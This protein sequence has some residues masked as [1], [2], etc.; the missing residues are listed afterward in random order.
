MIM[1]SQPGSGVAI[2]VAPKGWT[3]NRGRKMR[4]RELPIKTKLLAFPA[5]TVLGLFLMSCLAL[6]GTHEVLMDGHRKQLQSVLDV[7]RQI[8][9]HHHEQAKSGRITETEAKEQAKAALK[10]IRF[11]GNEYCF[12]YD[13]DG[14]NVMHPTRADFQGTDRRSVR[15]RDG[16]AYIQELLTAA[17]AG[18]GEV[19]Y[20]FTKPGTKEDAPKLGR[21]VGFDPWRWMI[22]GGVYVDDVELEV[23]YSVAKYGALTSLI[24]IA[25]I[26]AALLLGWEISGSIRHFAEAMD[27]LADGD[28]TTEIP[29]A[30]ARAE[31]GHMAEAMTVFKENAIRREQLETEQRR[32]AEARSRRQTAMEVLTSDFNNS[33]SGMLRTVASAAGELQD[34]AQSMAATALRTRQQSTSAAAAAEHA[35]GNVRTVASVAE[36]LAVS[37]VEIS[38]EVAR[39]SVIAASAVEEA[40]RAGATVAG[41]SEAAERIGVVVGLISDIAAQTN[42]LALNAT[43]E[44]ARAGDAG[45]GFAVVASEVKNL[46]NQTASATEEIAAQIGAVQG[47]AQDAVRT[48][49]DIGRTI[50]DIHDTASK[51]V[52][53][54]E[55]QSAAIREIALNVQ[56]ATAGAQEVSSTIVHVNDAAVVTGSASEQVLQ[57]AGSL[58]HESDT[59]R[60]QVEDF[61]RAIRDAGNRRSYERIEVDLPAV[62]TADGREWRCRVR[63]LALGGACVDVAVPFEIGAAFSLHLSSVGAVAGRLAGVSDGMTRLQFVLNS[64]TQD[65]LQP[66]VEACERRMA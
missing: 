4:L 13:Y 65:R 43:I 21:A 17:R 28:L 48:I 32:E 53:A 40:G 59:L 29:W 63:D 39:S 55:R 2:P 44:A 27:H 7:A 37:E 14:I 9:E 30:G 3:L 15:D 5:L 58:S 61:L 23:L 38:R 22:A 10:R 25:A 26:G 33:V 35:A 8:V 45:K 50:S 36:Q 18:S 51:V 31:L 66:L 12:I 20:S 54:V 16:V 34:T 62:L 57:A 52:E 11:N 42:L 6:I 19:I 1:A 56:Q 41:L 46:A 47:T 60:S 49:N 64:A 24:L